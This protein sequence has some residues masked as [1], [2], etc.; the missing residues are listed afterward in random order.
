M[1]PTE[2]TADRRVLSGVAHTDLTGQVTA[3]GDSHMKEETRATSQGVCTVVTFITMCSQ[4]GLHV[5]VLQQ[6][7][8]MKSITFFLLSYLF[9]FQCHSAGLHVRL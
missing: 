8:T 2:Y 6:R 5:F 3:G 7:K 1:I 4:I 9:T